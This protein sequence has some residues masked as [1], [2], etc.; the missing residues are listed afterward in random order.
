MD[1][2]LR[3]R[4]ALVTGG[5]GALGRHVVRR[6]L[7]AG[8][9]THV[10]VLRTEEGDEL[11]EFLGRSPDHL[12]LHPDAD[13]TQAP[14]VEGLMERVREG[15]GRTP[16]IVLNLAGGFQMAPLE[17]TDPGVWDRM[18]GMNATTAFLCSRAAFAGML[19][20][21]WGRIVNVSALPA[22]EGGQEGLS[23]YG[24]AKAA[25]LNLTRTLAREG[26]GRGISVN[27]ILPSII[28]T[29]A[30]RRAMPDADT[31]AWLP[32]EEIAEVLRFLLS[33]EARIVNGAALTLRLD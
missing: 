22:L 19:E 30:N 2:G 7:D 9:D 8:A 18:L 3:E 31:G 26:A 32:P 21:A 15:S 23:A 13:L 5:A 24:A 1:E 16:D 33:D 6:L 10:P 11:R 25:V 17:E 20:R 28:D 12:T 29:P 4:V 14:V 27:A